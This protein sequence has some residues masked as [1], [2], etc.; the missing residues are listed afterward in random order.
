MFQFTFLR[1]IIFFVKNQIIHERLYLSDYGI[2]YQSDYLNYL[3]TMFIKI[4][5]F[6]FNIRPTLSLSHNLFLLF[7]NFILYSLFLIGYLKTDFKNNLIANLLIITMI[8]SIMAHMTLT[9]GASPMRLQYIIFCPIFYFVI[10][11][12]NVLFLR[13]YLNK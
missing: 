1:E 12:I 7:Y 5:T 6:L 13:R 2:V 3:T 9:V 8:L 10:N 4:L 11:G